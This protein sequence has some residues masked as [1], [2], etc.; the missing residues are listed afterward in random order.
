MGS[1][2][3]ELAN[4]EI[5]KAMAETLERHYP[6]HAWAVRAEIS[7]GVVHVFNLALSG[8]WGFI[9]KMNDIMNDQGMKITI[10]AGGELLER[11]N[12]TRGRKLEKEYDD[13]CFDFKGEAIQ[14]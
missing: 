2:T 5:A 4:F 11:Y 6:G 1:M 7:N 10:R 13:I 12:L 8:K 9:L 3:E 14:A